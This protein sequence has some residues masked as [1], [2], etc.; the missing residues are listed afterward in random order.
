MKLRYKRNDNMMDKAT[1]CKI[2]PVSWKICVQG[3]NA[4]N[5]VRGFLSGM[6][7]EC[8]DL[9]KEPELYDPPIFGIVAT[10]RSETPLTAEELE[11]MLL[12]DEKIELAFDD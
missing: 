5:Y 8:S 2:R 4:A 11:A 1:V 10:G 3:E 6:R 7:F 12:E 9:E